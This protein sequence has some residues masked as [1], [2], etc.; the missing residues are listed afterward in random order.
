VEEVL[1]QAYPKVTVGMSNMYD[2]QWWQRL[3]SIWEV[4]I[5][6]PLVDLEAAWLPLLVLGTAVCGYRWWRRRT[7]PRN[8]LKQLR[9]GERDLNV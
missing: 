6:N 9:E 1:L 5:Y 8:R 3:I 7:G 4:L 2:S